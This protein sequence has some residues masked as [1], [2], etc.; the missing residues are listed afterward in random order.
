MFRYG[1]LVIYVVVSLLKNVRHLYDH[2][3]T[4][5]RISYPKRMQLIYQHAKSFARG[6]IDQSGSVITI[7]Q[8]KHLPEGPVIYVHDQLDA[9]NMVLLVGHLEKPTAFFAKPRLFR[10]PILR[11]WLKKM[12]VIKQNQSDVQLFNEAEERLLSGQS[13]LL[14]KEDPICTIALAEKTQCPIVPV[15]TV[16]TERLMRGK[17]FKR[18]HPVDVDMTIEAPYM[19][20]DQV[21]KR[22]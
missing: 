2:E 5:P 17:V 20:S 9:V 6:C 4:D 3:L 10:I 11:Q 22:A 1:F 12:Q 14:S 16:G 7:Y 8:Q 15:R 19:I 18:L 21:K 13:L